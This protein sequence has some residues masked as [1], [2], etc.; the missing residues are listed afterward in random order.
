MKANVTPSCRNVPTKC[1]YMGIFGPIHF[2]HFMER[3]EIT[4]KAG[5][6]RNIS[7]DE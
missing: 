3:K 6:R 7:D 5:V 1:A 4:V 2:V